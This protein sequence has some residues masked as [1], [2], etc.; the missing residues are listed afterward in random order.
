MKIV[1]C[2]D[3]EIFR[4]Q[5]KI[6]CERFI[7]ENQIECELL[8]CSS[9]EE[10]L[11][12][13]SVD[14]LLL[15]IEMR[16]MDGVQVKNILQEHRA[17]TRILFVSSHGE[18]M[19]E[20]YGREVYGFLCKPVEYEKFAAKMRFL[21]QDV[22][23]QSRYILLENKKST[24]KVLIK[25]ILYIKAEG[26]YTKVYINQREDY[27]FSDDT[28]SDWKDL[29]GNYGFG[30]CQRSY[31]VNY[32]YIKKIEHGVMLERSE[33]LPLSRRLEKEFREEYKKYV[34]RKAK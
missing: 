23:E 15:D 22:M 7:E 20:A 25:D 6:H 8:E 34:W 4:K 30:L 12:E 3:E 10:V 33:C 17:E 18:A 27:F 5:L 29:L 24:Q 9:G 26:K 16:G 32:N 13:D 14:V 21:L 2:D 31:L 1:I 28:I 11:Q 19:P